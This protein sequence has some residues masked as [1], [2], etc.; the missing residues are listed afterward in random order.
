VAREPHGTPAQQAAPWPEVPLDGPWQV[1]VP[2]VGLLAQPRRL[3]RG[4]L[5]V[6]RTS[7]CLPRSRTHQEKAP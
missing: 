2:P 1:V 3:G 6:G 4:L 7:Q 5:S